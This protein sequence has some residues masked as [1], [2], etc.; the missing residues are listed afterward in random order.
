MTSGDIFSYEVTQT[1]MQLRI[2]IYTKIY[3]NINIL[4]S[5]SKEIGLK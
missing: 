5:L 3:G 1:N 4:I 2:I